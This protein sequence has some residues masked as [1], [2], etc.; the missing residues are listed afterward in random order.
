MPQ[1]YRRT[2]QM[3]ILKTRFVTNTCSLLGWSGVFGR[4]GAQLKRRGLENGKC[5]FNFNMW[6]KKIHRLEIVEI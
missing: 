4:A 3:V 1:I 2:R 5:Q 6:M